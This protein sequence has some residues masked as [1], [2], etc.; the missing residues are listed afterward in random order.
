MLKVCRI[1][2]TTPKREGNM[3]VFWTL[4]LLILIVGSCLACAW[5]RDTLAYES[6]KFPDVLQ[7]ITGR[8]ERNP[9]LYYE[10]RLNRVAEE[11]KRHPQR[12]DLYDDAGVAA[13]RLGRHAE[14]LEW[15]GKKRQRLASLPKTRPEVK[16]HWYRYYANVGTFRA[17][18]WFKEGTDRKRIAEVKQARNEI[19]KAIQINPDAHFGREKYQ[20]MALEWIIRPVIHTYHR[21]DPATEKDEGANYSYSTVSFSDYLDHQGGRWSEQDDPIKGLTGLIVLG[22][23]WESVDVFD[24]LI[25]SL[26]YKQL[27]TLRHMALLR[28]R[29]LENKGR[30]SL[31]PHPKALPKARDGSLGRTPMMLGSA[32]QA[33]AT[34]NDLRREAD[35]W[36][37][38]RTEF[39]VASL[40]AG[41]HPDTDPNFWAGYREAEPPNL[42]IP[43]YTRWSRDMYVGMQVAVYGIL[44]GIIIIPVGLIYYVR[45]RE[46]KWLLKQLS[47]SKTKIHTNEESSQVDQREREEV[48]R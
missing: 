19:A 45:R 21:D 11:L 12:L 29:E 42:E 24:A 31:A 13:D 35:E 37:R 26:R 16:E 46:R 10:I 27:E 47:R 3:R 22:N 1:S 43:F 9:P 36:H 48:L 39:M 40:R 2:T 7:V 41:R 34:F 30:R 5:D 23:A 17:H 44:A 6:K 4:T 14:A 38:Q 33:V 28:R 25:P 15:M 32:K 8:F 20:L 18:R